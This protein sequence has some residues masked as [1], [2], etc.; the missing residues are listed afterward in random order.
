MRRIGGKGRKKKKVK[1]LGREMMMRE[2]L[3]V[4]ECK[5]ERK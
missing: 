5:K 2:G 3:C 4:D 1:K